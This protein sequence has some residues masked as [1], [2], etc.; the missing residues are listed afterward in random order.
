MGCCSSADK[1]SKQASSLQ[2]LGKPVAYS[3]EGAIYSAS[4]NPQLSLLNNTPDKAADF[5]FLPHL[6]ASKEEEGG[7]VLMA[8]AGEGN[9]NPQKLLYIVSGTPSTSPAVSK[10][11]SSQV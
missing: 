6:H 4:E 5:V 8:K 10:I 11:E 1:G 2:R 3:P 9:E 7:G